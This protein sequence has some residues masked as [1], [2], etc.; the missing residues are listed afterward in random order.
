MIKVKDDIFQSVTQAYSEKEKLF[1]G[2]TLVGNTWIFLFP[3]MPM[4]LT[5][6]YNLSRNAKMFTLLSCTDD[7]TYLI[8]L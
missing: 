5:E 8:T 1:I 6:K 3:S 2:L 4:S 7:N